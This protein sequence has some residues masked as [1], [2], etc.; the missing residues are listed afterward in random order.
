MPRL[1]GAGGGANRA[2]SGPEAARVRAV[3]E[4]GSP[5]NRA[6]AAVHREEPPRQ[7]SGGHL[8]GS[9]VTACAARSVFDR[10]IALNPW[11]LWHPWNPWNPWNDDGYF[12]NR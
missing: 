7:G 1:R 9:P 11:N 12:H 4:I 2:A 10:R 6:D 8:R 3:L 5:A